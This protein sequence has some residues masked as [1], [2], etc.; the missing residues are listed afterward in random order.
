MDSVFLY[1][2]ARRQFTT[3]KQA[4]RLWRRL[5]AAENKYYAARMD[6]YSAK[7]A[8]L[9]S[10]ADIVAIIRQALEIVD[11]RGTALRLLLEL[12][13]SVRREVFPTLVDVPSVGHRDIQRVRDVIL[14]IDRD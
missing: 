8:L 6:L 14:S 1:S 13:E 5:V 10:D 3:P 7:S 9:K 2:H 12:D 11:D 4:E